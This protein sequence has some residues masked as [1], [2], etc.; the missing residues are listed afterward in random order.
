MS[1]SRDAGKLAVE[2]LGDRRD[3]ADGDDLTFG[4]AADLE[5][6][7]NQFMHRLVGRFV[8]REGVWWVQ[9][10]GTR[11][12]LELL[13]VD[14]GTLVELAPG[15]QLPI[16]ARTFVVRFTAGPTSYELN[17]V[18]S[19]E[20]LRADAAGEVVGTATV[21][22][23]DVPL[24][25][26]QH[27][28]VVALFE[29]KLRTGRIEGGSV[30]AAR[31]GWSANKFNRKLDVVCEKL[32]RAGVPGVK[33]AVGLNADGRRETL[34]SWALSNGV[35]TRNDLALVRAATSRVVDPGDVANRE[36]PLDLCVLSGLAVAVVPRDRVVVLDVQ[37]PGAVRRDLASVVVEDAHELVEG[38]HVGLPAAE[39]RHRFEHALDSA[40]PGL[41][42]DQSCTGRNAIGPAIALGSAEG[43]G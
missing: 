32:H 29:S 4:R 40:H 37:L 1:G 27:L 30:M 11:S 15:Q 43:V 9:N 26:E 41:D 24:S 8:C 10:L 31:L 13:D 19:G 5:V 25:P 34:L 3:L 28:L 23:G 42:H 20:P 17:G 39:E 6:D 7:D 18:R 2:F 16:V 22:F 35:V 36:V 38:S 12:R 33:G 21:D 14:S